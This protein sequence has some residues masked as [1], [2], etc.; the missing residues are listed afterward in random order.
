[1]SDEVVAKLGAQGA[2][3]MRANGSIVEGPARRVDVLDPVGAG[4]AFAAGYVSGRLRGLDDDAV[5]AL[6]NGCGALAVASIGDT[7]GLPSAAELA[8]LAV[9]ADEARR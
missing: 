4:D 2:A 3:I 8:H 9:G 6:A 1:M 5:L 7:T